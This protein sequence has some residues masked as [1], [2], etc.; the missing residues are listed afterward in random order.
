MKAF[1]SYSH[2]DSQM[3]D[4]LHKH[5]AQLQRDAI[6]STWT[7]REINAGANLEQ[8]ISSAL[9]N[10]QIFIALL[11]PDYIVSNYCYEKEFTTAL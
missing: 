3:L 4:L 5:L 10:S 9:G 1:I 2:N 8:T 11:S 6:I 7:D